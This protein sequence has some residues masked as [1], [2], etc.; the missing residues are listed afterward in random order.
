MERALFL[1]AELSSALTVLRRSLSRSPRFRSCSLCTCFAAVA[2]A[3]DGV[4][5][6]A[7]EPAIAFRELLVELSL[8][9]LELVATVRPD[10][11]KKLDMVSC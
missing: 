8:P 1:R 3:V 7:P 6:A 9:G 11:R 2:A 10:G 5:V 4:I